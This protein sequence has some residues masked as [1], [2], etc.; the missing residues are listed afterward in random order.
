M[1][2]QLFTFDQVAKHNSR[3][4]LWI[5]IEGKVYDITKFQ[6]EVTKKQH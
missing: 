3:R 4:D 5:I 6:D 1:S 2:T